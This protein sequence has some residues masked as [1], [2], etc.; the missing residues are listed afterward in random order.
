MEDDFKNIIRI[1]NREKKEKFNENN[2]DVLMK[3]L[4]EKEK[5]KPI[6]NNN[7]QV[8]SITYNQNNP[9]HG[10]ENK[11]EPNKKNDNEDND[12]I[13]NEF[14]EQKDKD[15][16]NN[17]DSNLFSNDKNKDYCS[18][19]LEFPTY[20]SPMIYSQNSYQSYRDY[21]QIKYKKNSTAQMSEEEDDFEE[22]RKLYGNSQRDIKFIVDNFRESEFSSGE[23][24]IGGKGSNAF[25]RHR[26][27]EYE[28]NFGGFFGSKYNNDNDSEE[29]YPR[30]IWAYI[31]KTMPMIVKILKK[32]PL[33]E[34]DESEITTI[35]ICRDYI[36][37]IPSALE[38]FL[39]AIDWLNP[40]QVSIAHEYIKKW[41]K[42]QVEDAIS[43]LDARFPDTETREFAVR[44]LRDLP[45]ELIN[46]YML[47]LCQCLLYETFLVNPLSDFLIERSLT[48]PKLIGNAF[49]F[50]SHIAI[51]FNYFNAGTNIY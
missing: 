40:L 15:N 21:L 17:S 34:L 46:M 39:R 30:D 4:E 38:L 44:M 19:S 13:I 12:N 26:D 24:I 10:H 47:Q 43:L 50:N 33:D 5:K 48:N 25:G 37:T 23:N 14:N 28:N 36:S 51:L 8:Q 6:D 22:I 11:N 2:I 27:N 29:I 7:N 35:L 31:K 16:E 9:K 49:F 1:Y 42:L 45:D 20:S 18:I 41:A 3:K 32:D